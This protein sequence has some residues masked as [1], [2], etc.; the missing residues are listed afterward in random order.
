MWAQPQW[1]NIDVNIVIIGSSAKSIH[2]VDDVL[3]AEY[4]GYVVD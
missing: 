1:R 3:R 2:N 4:G